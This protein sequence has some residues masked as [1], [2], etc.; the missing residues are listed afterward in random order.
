MSRPQLALQVGSPPAR[1]P[2]RISARAPSLGPCPA[3]VVGAALCATATA[4]A[5]RPRVLVAKFPPRR[6]R[7]IEGARLY[8]WPQ[9]GMTSVVRQRRGRAPRE[10]GALHPVRRELA[11]DV[12]VQRDPPGMV[13]G[14]WRRSGWQAYSRAL[15]M[16][17]SP[18]ALGPSAGPPIAPGSRPRAERHICQ[19]WGPLADAAMG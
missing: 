2:A 4:T 1:V 16:D 5:S 9:A 17:Q 6:L 19:L 7:S 11:S 15:L 3:A 10:R 13:I 8:G 12:L 18:A 14:S